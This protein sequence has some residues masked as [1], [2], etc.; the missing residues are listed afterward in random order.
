MPFKIKLTGLYGER[1]REMQRKLTYQ[2]FQLTFKSANVYRY[3]GSA[4]SVTPDID[5]IQSKVFYETPDRVYADESVPISIAIEPIPESQ[6]DFSRFGIIAPMSN[7]VTI[8]VHVDEFEKCL[9]RWLIVGDVLEIPFY[10]RECKRAFWEVT[11]VDD[12]PSYEKFYVTVTISPLKDSRKTHDIEKD[13]SNFDFNQEI[14][15]IQDQ[16]AFDEVPVAGIG[17]EV[18]AGEPV[19][20]RRKKQRSFLDDPDA[21]F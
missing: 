20:P 21:E 19:D 17:N 11:D 7:E 2:A 14:Q 16:E 3:L 1:T 4:E 15:E 18:D 5:D 9:G 8:R 10:K 12:K 6:M 13:R